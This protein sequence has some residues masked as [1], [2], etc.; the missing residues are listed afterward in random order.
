MTF[1]YVI[2]ER[3]FIRTN[4]NV[5]KIGRSSNGIIRYNSYPKNSILLFHRIC[6]DSI[7]VETE[8]IRTLKTKCKHRTEYGNEYFEGDYTIIINTLNKLIDQQPP[9]DVL[10]K[11]ESKTS[12]NISP[13]NKW[14]D[15]FDISVIK[16]QFVV[17]GV[18]YLNKNEVYTLF[19]D[20][21]EVHRNVF[22]R[23][24]RS[25][26]EINNRKRKGVN[27]INYTLPKKLDEPEV[28]QEVISHQLDYVVIFVCYLMI[29][30]AYMCY[31]MKNK[32]VFE[33]L[34][35]VVLG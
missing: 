3:E 28:K 31:S 33:V 21:H 19:S 6:G 16:D 17:D 8:V 14:W 22:W 30:T 32:N 12:D 24:S 4:E 26:L 2:K 29:G 20:E 13:I 5:Y 35:S 15:T 1:I 23:V 7:K 25:Y 18:V 10:V 9:C 34:L 11:I 27:Y